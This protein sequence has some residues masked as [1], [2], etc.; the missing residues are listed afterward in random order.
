MFQTQ[1]AVGDARSAACAGGSSWTGAAERP[2]VSR[3]QRMLWYGFE[4]V[5]MQLLH[6]A[7]PTADPQASIDSCQKTVKL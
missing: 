5:H 7:V 2:H 3:C 4:L 1:H 6:P